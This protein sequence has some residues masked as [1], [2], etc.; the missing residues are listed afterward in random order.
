MPFLSPNHQCESAEGNSRVLMQT[1]PPATGER[2][3][4]RNWLSDTSAQYNV[5]FSTWYVIFTRK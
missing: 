4:C 2:D 1:S 3:A 5:D